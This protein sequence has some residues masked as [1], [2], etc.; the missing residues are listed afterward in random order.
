MA[1]GQQRYYTNLA[2]EDPGYWIGE[3]ARLLGLEGDVSA[4][5]LR[6]L[7]SGLSPDGSRFLVQHQT[8]SDGRSRQPG[9]DLTFSAPK[10]VSVLLS[11]AEPALRHQIIGA[12]RAAVASALA[13]LEDE[14]LGTRRGGG[15]ARVEP[16]K[17]VAAAFE[18][19]TSRALDPQL[20]THV[21]VLNVAPRADESWGTLRSRDLYEHKM[22]AGEL[23]KAELSV[24]LLS[25][26][27]EIRRT[28]HSVEIREVP[29]EL[30]RFFSKRRKAIEEA[31]SQNAQQGAK[32]A[33]AAARSTRP[34][35]K[36]IS[37]EDLFEGWQKQGASQGFSQDRARSYFGASRATTERRQALVVSRFAARGAK[38]LADRQAAF[39]N[40]GLI[41]WVASNIRANGVTA[42]A[43]RNGVASY[44]A[45]SQD[46]VR[47][48]K[49]GR[50]QRFTTREMF[51]IEGALLADAQALSCDRSHSIDH[52]A[53][54]DQL[55]EWQRRSRVTLTGEQSQAVIQL[56]TVPSA[57]QCLTG[58]AGTGKTLLLAAAR[59]LWE[60]A[61]YTVLGCALSS[62]AS[63]E[64]EKGSGIKSENIR[65]TL[66]SISP[67]ATYQL[68]HH[69][70]QLL[71][72]A[73][74]RRTYPIDRT[75]ITSKT[76]LVI[77]E[78]NMVG[79]RDM[80]ALIAE[81][82]G[83]GG[84][85]ICS[86]DKDQLT[87]IDA[88][89]AFQ[90]F[91]ELYG[92]AELIDIARQRE[93]W[94]RTAIKQVVEGDVRGALSQYAAA[95][96]V[97]LAEKKEEA[98]ASL[99]DHWDKARTTDLA[100]TLVI[101]PTNESCS[102][103]NRLAQE[104][105]RRL[106]ELGRLRTNVNGQAFHVGDRV[107]FQANNRYLGVANG[108]QGTIESIQRVGLLKPDI[109]TV[110]LDRTRKTILGEKPIRVTFEVGRKAPLG[111]GYA[112]TTHRGQ[113]ATVEKAFVLTEGIMT[114][115]EQLYVMLSRARAE[116][117]LFA[118]EH[119]A[120]EDLQWLIEAA[121][122]S[123]QKE[124][125]HMQAMSQQRM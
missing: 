21:L 108:D 106:R 20:H 35:K 59:D 79:T 11:Q 10:S 53:A 45:E 13:Y 82:R 17:L 120:G 116:T 86:G 30:S 43:I 75:R 112:V 32:Q 33:E 50:F 12:H 83:T 84:K 115:R 117:S 28:R 24:G 107:I 27:L 81:V 80:Q 101:A 76:V 3:G 8:Y 15:G 62:K 96:C 63:R 40:A 34:R 38:A 93:P 36:A 119:E 37:S 69:G 109:L 73:Q 72:A 2:R 26:G 121:E 25:H 6:Y 95:G 94:Q 46:I 104:R 14:V 89:G 18:H 52:E 90:A 70:R 64:L 113:G 7:F 77:D 99:I 98:L 9:W 85:V 31:L 4:Q 58:I 78:A 57:L 44:L 114:N 55:R 103:L 49:P 102:K 122:Q 124:L 110:R 105:R 19:F 39:T 92:A 68:K 66:L 123:Y 67:P 87:A 74:R 100:E 42:K 1:S 22:V 56:V 125:A 118:T 91:I 61:G 5:D 41:R 97:H 54:D 111:L 48:S 47:L 29:S 23:Y 60:K 65:K 51:A 71:R 88:G 16:T